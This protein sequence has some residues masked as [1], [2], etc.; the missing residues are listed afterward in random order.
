MDKATYIFIFIIVILSMVVGISQSTN[1]FEIQSRGSKQSPIQ[2]QKNI[3]ELENT[4]ADT[5]VQEQPTKNEH[6]PFEFN[7][8][9]K[10]K[11]QLHSSNLTQ[12][13]VKHKQNK[14]S[15]SSDFLLWLTLFIL[16]FI[17]ILLSINRNLITKII[18]VVWYYNNTNYLLR[19]FNKR[20]F[21]FYFFLFCNFIFNLSIFI[22]I[23]IKNNHGFS[24]IDFFIR[25]LG[26]V[27]LVYIIKH[28][29]IILFNYT[30]P[31]LKSMVL[32]NFT[33]LLFNISLGIFLIPINLIITYSVSSISSIFV[34]F[35]LVIIGIMYLIR[36]FRGFL[37][38]YNYFTISIFH[39]FIYL[40]A[41]EI[42][43]LLFLYMFFM[44]Y[45]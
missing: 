14:Y 41:F 13:N 40:C 7:K 42:L 37:V 29:T 19:S 1:P 21:L 32:Y 44:N 6:N 27:A 15:G 4:F 17:A 18:K 5:T 11:K 22:Y 28:L 26:L 31:S 8:I 35:G 23:F 10:K 20:E 45:L 33:I 30:F 2:S 36:L 39:F 16:V 24:G 25:I 43:P 9:T 3:F 38:T 12:K 34:I